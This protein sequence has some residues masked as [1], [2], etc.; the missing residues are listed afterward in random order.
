MLNMYLFPK[1]VVRY[2]NTQ[3]KTSI[4]Q[5]K[6]DT[7]DFKTQNISPWPA[8][9]AGNFLAIYYKTARSRN[10]HTR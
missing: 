1:L 2:K 8:V 4:F 7:R 6:K 5:A 3:Q 9:C 10:E